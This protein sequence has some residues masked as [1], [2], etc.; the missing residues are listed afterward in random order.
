[1]G[2]G[3]GVIDRNSVVWFNQTCLIH[4]QQTFICH[5]EEKNIAVDDF[6]A[7]NL[8]KYC[9]I[10]PLEKPLHNTELSRLQLIKD[11]NVR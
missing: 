9:K 4:S 8:I 5:Y 3:G 1:M 6:T 10:I 2:G 11:W 7:S